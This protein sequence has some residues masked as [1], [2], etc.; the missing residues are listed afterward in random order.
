MADQLI[1]LKQEKE[2]LEAKA[3]ESLVSRYGL[4]TLKGLQNTPKGILNA[5]EDAIE[6]PLQ[7]S[8]LV[9]GSAA[10]GALVKTVL[11]KTGNYGKAAAVVIGGY[12]TYRAAEPVL[13]AYKIAGNAK[14]MTDMNVAGKYLGD[15]SGSLLLNTAIA[16]GSYKLGSYAAG[17]FLPTHVPAPVPPPTDGPIK[18]RTWTASVAGNLPSVLSVGSSGSTNMTFNPKLASLERFDASDI[19]PPQ[20]E[21]KGLVELDSEMKVTVQL[22]SKASEK[23]IEETLDKIAS[24]KLP[25]LTDADFAEKF[26]ASKESLDA[27]KRFAEAYSLKVETAD[28]RSGRVVISGSALNLSEAFKTRIYEF[29]SDGDKH[30]GRV[31]SLFVPRVIGDKIEGIFGLDGRPVAK[32]RVTDEKK[33]SSANA[34]AKLEQIAFRPDEIADIYNFP[35]GTTG[36]GQGVAIIQLGGAMKMDNEQSYYKDNGLKVPEIKIT[37]LEGAK[38]QFGLNYL[39]DKEVSLD[40]QVLGAV[41]PDAKQNIIFAPNSEKGF[42]DAIER[43]AFPEKD[44]HTNHAIS[45]SWGQPIESWSEQAKRGMHK[46]LQKA[47]LKGISIFAASGD[48]GAV[49]QSPSGTFQV[50]Y[51]AADPYVTG[52]G[53]T[54]LVMKD[55]KLESEVAWNDRFGATGGGIS[56]KTDFSA[57]EFQKGLL[58]KKEES[59]RG[60]PDIS[61]N[62]SPFSGYKIRFNGN[63]ITTGGTSAAA[64]LLAG[65]VL[66]INEALGPGK[67]VGYMNPFLYKQATD[68]KASFIRDIVS[69]NNNGYEAGKGW[70][71]VTGWGVLNGE[72]L[73]KAY[74][75][76]QS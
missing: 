28:L 51:P 2:L 70:D 16:A 30:H 32:P 23:E 17:R 22:K 19:K 14:T 56:A 10:L 67:Q 45:I 7:T 74:K 54:R 34:E 73:L 66:R 35:K 49:N 12:L 13:D 68:G 8:G 62:A 4:L 64:P 61:A 57:P 42:I 58:P 20:A 6:N 37:H 21:L 46:N 59:G 48:A 47:A 39:A 53:G 15:L 3:P 18:P 44:E 40:S 38:K 50:D 24:G 29:E 65:L 5:A 43:A 75:A 60:V 36:K 11:P 9:I 33:D 72:E 71:P 27:L 63:D 25:P 52:V 55:G 31:G 41:A 76:R 26:G 69:G 1:D